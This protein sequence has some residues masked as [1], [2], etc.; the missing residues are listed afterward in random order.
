MRRYVASVSY[1][2][3]GATVELTPEGI[4][5]GRRDDGAHQLA[6]FTLKLPDWKGHRLEADLASEFKAHCIAWRWLPPLRSHANPVDL[7]FH[8]AWPQNLALSLWTMIRR[9]L[10]RR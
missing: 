6:R 5:F 8:V 10:R 3:G 4:D 7:E 9:S 1:W 2:R